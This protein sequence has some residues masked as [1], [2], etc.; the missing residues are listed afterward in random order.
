MTSNIPVV[1]IDGPSGSG[2]GT[3][4]MMLADKLTWHYL[5]SGALYRAIG[6][7]I[8]QGTVNLDDEPELDQFLAKTKI[9]QQYFHDDQS[10][11]VSCNGYDISQAIRQEEVGKMASRCAALFPVRSKLLTLQRECRVSPG[12]VADGRDMGTVIFPDAVIKFYLEASATVRAER[13]FNQLKE[14][15]INVSLVDIRHELELRDQR[16][17][18]RSLSPAK[19]APDVLLIDTS[20]LTISEVFEKIMEPLQ[21]YL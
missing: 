6:W 21:A 5:D 19:P 13:R 1:T 14:Q 18:N 11:R 10:V 7:A 20:A 3:L 15:D 16:D 8:L 4:S 9:S 2:K 12:L 17:A